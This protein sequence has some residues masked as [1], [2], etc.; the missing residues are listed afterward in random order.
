MLNR[1]VAFCCILVVLCGCDSIEDNTLVKSE[2]D[3]VKYAEIERNSG[4]FLK[5]DKIVTQDFIR[6]KDGSVTSYS[7]M[8]KY[9]IDGKPYYSVCVTFSGKVT[10][11]DGDIEN[12]PIPE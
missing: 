2:K 9:T 10:V 8:I 4:E 12:C 5:I 7:Y 6:E 3:A 1:I 11:H